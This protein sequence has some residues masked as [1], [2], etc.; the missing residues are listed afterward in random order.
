[1]RRTLVGGAALLAATVACSSVVVVLGATVL[2]VEPAAPRDRA[3]PAFVSP[4]GRP[5]QVTVL[6][7]SLSSASRYRWPDEVGAELSRRIA[8]PVEVHRVA[9]PGGTSTWGTTQIERV[10][11]TRPDVVVVELS[12]NDA[13]VR[14]HLSVRDSVARH[15]SILDG[16]ASAR[17][18]ASVVLVTMSP[19][20]GPRAWARPFLSRYYA[21]YVALAQR[22]DAGLVD[23]YP[24]W[25]ALPADERELG[26]GLHPSDT[27]ATRVVVGPVVGILAAAAAAGR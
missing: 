7:T 27:A 11:A 1:V 26:D 20:V 21:A 8:R 22:H 6:G 4:E 15:E 13:D 12:V 19:A 24:R 23:L 2:A 3:A 10:A 17:P 14:H 9:Q 25:N 16:L 5:L 18:E